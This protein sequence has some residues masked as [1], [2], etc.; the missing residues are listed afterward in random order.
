MP[1]HFQLQEAWAKRR[2]ISRV[3]VEKARAARKCQNGTVWYL[4]LHDG[5]NSGDRIENFQPDKSAQRHI[6]TAP[7]VLFSPKSSGRISR[8]LPTMMWSPR[9]CFLTSTASRAC[10]KTR[11]TRNM[12]NQTTRILRIWEG[13]STFVLLLYRACV[14]YRLIEPYRMSIGWIEDI[15]MDGKVLKSTNGVVDEAVKKS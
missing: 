4:A 12:C 3:H 10:W 13:R 5:M 14:S 2:R 11:T 15:V 1:H 7:P 8:I 6:T 9:W